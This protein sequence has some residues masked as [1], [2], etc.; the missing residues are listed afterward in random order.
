MKKAYVYLVLHS[1]NQS[2]T[3][4]LGVCVCVCVRERERERERETDRQTDRQTQR[5]RQRGG[6]W[7]RQT[8]RRVVVVGVVA[9][10][11]YPDKTDLK[12]EEAGAGR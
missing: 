3:V 1:L 2:T 5:K 9:R 10:D 11:A 4:I 12:K 8:D 7:G 6:G